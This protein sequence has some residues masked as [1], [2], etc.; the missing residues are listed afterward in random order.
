[1]RHTRL[2]VLL[3]V[4]VGLTGYL[5][6]WNDWKNGTIMAEG[7]S[8]VGTSEVIIKVRVIPTS[9]PVWGLIAS[10]WFSGNPYYRCE[11]YIFRSSRIHSCQ[12][13]RGESYEARS[14]SIRWDQSA[15]ATVYLD[16]IPVLTCDPHGF[17][18]K[19]K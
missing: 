11:Y 14:A 3:F 6:L 5:W 9:A 12:T 2:Y 10:R 19:A 18:R 7:K 17:W 16:E 8:T 15:G 4:A 13:Y 1:M